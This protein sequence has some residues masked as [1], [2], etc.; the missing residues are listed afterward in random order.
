MQ[1]LHNTCSIHPG[2][3]SHML[4]AC[5]LST[6]QSGNALKI[7]KLPLVNPV[8]INAQ[9]AMCVMFLVIR[10]YWRHTSVIN[11][12]PCLQAVVPSVQTRRKGLLSIS[13]VKQVQTKY[14]TTEKFASNLHHPPF[15]VAWSPWAHCSSVNSL[16]CFWTQ[17]TFNKVVLL[18]TFT[19]FHS[20]SN[21]SIRLPPTFLSSPERFKRDSPSSPLPLIIP[22]LHTKTSHQWDKSP[23][24]EIL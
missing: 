14:K 4:S 21:G 11:P 10:I 2:V 1:I 6:I 23:N 18:F 9:V 3:S 13:N 17:I 22:R 20:S 15:T 16:S 8:P 19:L 7:K 24:T 5:T 12:R